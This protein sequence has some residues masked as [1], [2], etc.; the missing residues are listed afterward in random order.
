MTRRDRYQNNGRDVKS[1]TQWHIV[2][3][4]LIMNKRVQVVSHMGN[5]WIG[6]WANFPQYMYP[7]LKLKKFSE[8]L[9]YS[10]QAVARH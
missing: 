7:T 3:I 1:H 4:E 5:S 8:C 6:P 2:G 10:E 9:H